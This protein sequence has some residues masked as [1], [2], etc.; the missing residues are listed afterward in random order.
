MA[1]QDLE[2]IAWGLLQRCW[3]QIAIYFARSI[4]VRLLHQPHA[5]ISS[6]IDVILS[7]PRLS[8]AYPIR[9][10]SAFNI[11]NQKNTMLLW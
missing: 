7:N 8:C 4:S 5:S 3:L 6:A 1:V 9:A 10:P 11:I 2:P